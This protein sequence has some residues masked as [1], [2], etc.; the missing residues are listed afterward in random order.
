MKINYEK[1]IQTEKN[2]KNYRRHETQP[3]KEEK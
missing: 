2:G 1:V 3:T